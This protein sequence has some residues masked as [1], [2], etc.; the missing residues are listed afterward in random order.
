MNVPAVQ[1]VIRNATAPPASASTRLSTSS[2]RTSRQRLAP[3]DIRTAISRRR[4]TDRTSIR[5]A[6]FAQ[7]SSSTTP[8]MV[9]SIGSSLE[10]N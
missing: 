4:A 5:F 8:A 3:S 6:T 7:A 10:R 2:C 9:I 1:N